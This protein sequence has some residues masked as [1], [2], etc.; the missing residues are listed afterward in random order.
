MV[1]DNQKNGLYVAKYRENK[2]KNE[3]A[4]KEYNATKLL[5]LVISQTTVK[6]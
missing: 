5:V 4:K 3:E 2:K 6:N 1:Q